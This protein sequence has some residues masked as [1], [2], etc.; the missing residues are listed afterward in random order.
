MKIIGSCKKINPLLPLYIIVGLLAV[1]IPLRTYQFLFITEANTGFYRTI[2]WSVYVIYGLSAVAILISYIFVNL[3]KN[4]PASKDEIRKKSPILAI[5]SVAFA[6]GVAIDSVSS[7]VSILVGQVAPENMIAV[8]IEAVFGIFAAI[9]IL[10]FGVSHFDGKTTYSQH[11]FLA[12]AP[13]FWVSGRII[14]RIMKKIAYVNIADLMLEIALLGFMMMFF[15]SFAR[16][17]TGLSTEK[18]MRSLFASGYVCLFF[19]ALANISRLVLK[20]TG[21]G[22]LLAAEYPVSVSDLFFAIFV[23]AYIVN[24][25]K[26]ATVNDHSEIHSEEN[27]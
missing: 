15:L 17:S 16:I 10:I 3:A 1:S 20:L 26:K 14:I 25:M 23:A 6:L 8:W 9:Y 4:V 19:C 21:N 2:D 11:K 13:L 24:A 27:K 12:L 7:F 5:A 18:S 22:A